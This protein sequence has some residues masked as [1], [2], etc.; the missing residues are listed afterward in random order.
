MT[1]DRYLVVGGAGVAGQAA[2]AAIRARTPAAEILAT[3]STASR[4][5]PGASRVVGGVDLREPDCIDALVSQIDAQIDGLVFTP[6]RGPVGFP[7]AA[8]SAAQVAEARAFSLAPLV[9]LRRRLDPALTIGFSSF[10]WLPASLQA[11]GAMAAVKREMEAL[12]RDGDGRLRVLRSGVFASHSGKALALAVYQQI[13]RGQQPALAAEWKGSARRF[14]D[15]FFAS[16]WRA[17]VEAFGARFDSPHRPTA[18]ADLTAALG[19]MLDRASAPIV[20]LIGDWV[21]EESVIPPLPEPPTGP[22]PDG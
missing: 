11:Y 21:W 18:P 4:E 12:A 16:A 9:E 22:T 3:T 5:I 19:G 20:N 15:F 13:R 7:V 6:A 14:F 10:W 17:E 1:T 8:A 2:I